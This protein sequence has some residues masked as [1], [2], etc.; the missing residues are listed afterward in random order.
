MTSPSLLQQWVIEQAQRRPD[1]TALVMGAERMTY[2]ELD[3]LS[4]RLAHTLKAAG[5][6]RGDRVCF[7]LPKSPI[8]IASMLG[9]LKADCTYIPADPSSPAPRIAKI[10][11]S[12]EPKVLFAVSRVARLVDELLLDERLRAATV[13]GWLDTAREGDGGVKHVAASFTLEDV[14]RAPD[15]PTPFRNGTRDPAHI[16]FTSGSTGTPKGVVITHGSVISFVEWARGY[17]GLGPDDRVSGH[18]PLHFDLSTFDVFGTFAAGAQ[19]HLVPPELNVLPTALAQLIRTAELTQWF[20]VP[21]LL[22]YLAKFDVVRFNDFPSL[23]RLLWCGEVFP[24]PALRYWMMRLPHVKFTNL[25][26]PT[27][28]TIASSHYTLPACPQDDLAAIPIGA[29]C[30]GEELLVLNEQLQRVPPGEVGDL[31]IRGVGLSPGYWRDPEKTHAAFLRN[32]FASDP[33]DRI[34]RTGDLARIGDDGLVYFLGRADSQIKSRGYR[35]ELGEIETALNTLSSIQE[36]AVVGV[37]TDGFEGTAI[38]CAYVPAPGATVTPAE[39]RSALAKVLPPPMLPSRWMA[40]Q[41]LPRNANG[42]F[43]RRQLR[44]A[45]AKNEAVTAG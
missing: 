18:P 2:G 7:L 16:L 3:A 42:K 29:P 34:Y 44:E 45:F 28:T 12:G 41:R 39:L 24:T 14:R 9:I 37:S 43:D 26:G 35:I 32:P 27:E 20:S 33:D 10:V 36:C 6:E 8:A 23:R 40:Y 11:Q 21:S 22:G 25:Y 31:Y 5:C 19:I 17:F 1:A 38:G 15:S 4:N 13:V 30:A